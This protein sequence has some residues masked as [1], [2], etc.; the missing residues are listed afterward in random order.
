MKEIVYRCDRCNRQM[1]IPA[2]TYT[3]ETKPFVLRPSRF[4]WHYCERCFLKINKVMNEKEFI[5]G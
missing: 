2:Y 5:D 4:Q 1:A 3:L